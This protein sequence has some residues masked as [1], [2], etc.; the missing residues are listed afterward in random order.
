M[1]LKGVQAYCR[2]D[3]AKLVLCKDKSFVDCCTLFQS[4]DA[5][6][7]GFITEQTLLRFCQEMRQTFTKSQTAYIFK[8]FPKA[9]PEKV[10]MDEFTSMIYPE[11]ASS[12]KSSPSGSEKSDSCCSKTAAKIDFCLFLKAFY[13]EHFEM[14]QAIKQMQSAPLDMP[15]LFALLQ[16]NQD[17]F[18]E[19]RQVVEFVREYA[20]LS[21]P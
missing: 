21:K 10:L 6:G 17:R 16:P 2:I 19:A 5:E 9:S 11:L 14:D 7:Q 15:Q 13:N 8:M 12:P 3:K 4:I 18:V 1:L 20:E